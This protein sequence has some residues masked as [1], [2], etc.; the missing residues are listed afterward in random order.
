M[1]YIAFIELFKR[2]KNEYPVFLVDDFDTAIDVENIDFLIKNYPELQVIATSVNKNN[3]FN[4]L[5]ELRK[6]N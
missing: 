3:G 2:Q 4:R 5:I 6:E 1:L